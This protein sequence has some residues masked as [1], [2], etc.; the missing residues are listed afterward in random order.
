VFLRIISKSKIR[1]YCLS[2]TRAELPLVEWYIKMKHTN[3]SN[4]TELKKVSNSVD[5]VSGYTVFDIGGNKYRLI[6]AIHFSTQLCF[7]REIWTHAEYSKTQN[8]DKLKRKK[9]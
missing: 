9:L 6:S 1:D 4:L 3:A 8:Q 5:Y 7:I 2:N